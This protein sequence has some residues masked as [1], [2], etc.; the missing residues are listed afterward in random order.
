MFTAAARIFREKG[1]SAASVQ[2]IAEAAGMQ[3]GGLYYYIDSKEDLLYQIMDHG[4]SVLLASLEAIVSKTMAPSQKLRL[5]IES[6]I[7]SIVEDPDSMIVALKERQALSPGH[8][9]A[10]VIKR[11]RYEALFRQIIQEGI[12]RNEFRPVDEKLTVFALL[13]MCNGVAEWYRPS[14]PLPPRDVSRFF[15]QFVLD[16]IR[17]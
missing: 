4:I 3:K 12:R 9:S 6:N 8:L 15:S 14:G 10:Y 13:A 1:Y 17:A 2:D 7:I 5:A 16:A 11:D